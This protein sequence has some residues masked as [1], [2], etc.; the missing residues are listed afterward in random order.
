[1]S[2]VGGNPMA[3]GAGQGSRLAAQLAGLALLALQQA[4]RVRE[5]QEQ[6]RQQDL[7]G[8]AERARAELRAQHAEARPRWEPGLSSEIGGADLRQAAEVWTAA[9]PWQEHDRTAK[10]AA[11][12]AEA[13]MSELQPDLMA[14]YRES[15]TQGVAAPEAMVAAHKSLAEDQYRR[16]VPPDPF[17]VQGARVEVGDLDVAGT[18]RA[19]QAAR[20]WSGHD[21]RAAAAMTNAEDQLRR[22]RPAAMA[23]YDER[24]AM[25]DDPDRAMGAAMPQ[26]TER[27][28]APA[29]AAGL[30][31]GAPAAARSEGNDYDESADRASGT[32]DLA[33]TPN[34]DERVEGLAA[35]A[36]ADRVAHGSMARSAALASQAFPQPVQ[37]GLRTTVTP[38]RAA[39]AAPAQ[40][41]RR[42][43]GR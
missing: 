7:A 13:R 16:F 8:E 11:D 4:A 35:S 23:T 10:Q 5:R 3:E 31:P 34:V 24:R 6:Q 25:G 30:D 14:R 28:W 12:A 1:M 36:G 20:L 18:M 42:G 2:D 38:A 17:P 9:V 33:S 39:A 22:L 29:P 15:R 26:M 21:E 41:P 37:A 27:V 40:Q 32:P 19:W 43:R